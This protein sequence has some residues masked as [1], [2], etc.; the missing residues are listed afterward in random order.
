MTK[1]EMT[2]DFMDRL[3]DAVAETL[4]RDL[5]EIFR[6]KPKQSDEIVA[7][8]FDPEDQMVLELAI[9]AEDERYV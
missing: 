5:F 7:I 9:R 2:P 8:N 3:D 4:P 1:K 6:D